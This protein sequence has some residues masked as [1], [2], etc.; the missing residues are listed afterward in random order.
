[1]VE[2]RPFGP[3]GIAPLLP[4]SVQGPVAQRTKGAIE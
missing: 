4:R 3:V 2:E 1:M